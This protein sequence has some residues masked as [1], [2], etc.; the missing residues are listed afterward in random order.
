MT[1]GV[2]ENLIHSQ[3]KPK[4]TQAKSKSTKPTLLLPSSLPPKA[5]SIHRETGNLLFLPYIN[6]CKKFELLKLLLFLCYFLIVRLQCFL[7]P[8]HFT[9]LCFT[10]RGHNSCFCIC[11]VAI[12][13]WL[14]K[15]T[16][17]NKATK[18]FHCLLPTKLNSYVPQG[19]YAHFRNRAWSMCSYNSRLRCSST[20]KH[21]SKSV[22][23]G[24]FSNTIF[25][26]L[27]FKISKQPWAFR[28]DLFSRFL[29]PSSLW[30][31]CWT[32]MGHCCNVQCTAAFSFCC[33]FCI[34]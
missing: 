19:G 13:S 10:D 30:K 14:F 28:R 34:W 18:A 29:Q 4:P 11:L 1:N 3:T 9:W 32:R 33:L 25:I 8:V 15:K 22:I 26:V 23:K 16:Q 2:N 24:I 20:S 31:T 21:K 5:H 7:F 27:K 6:I 12:Y 17:Q